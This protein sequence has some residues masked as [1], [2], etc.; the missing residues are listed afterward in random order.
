MITIPNNFNEQH[1]G[2]FKELIGM[3]NKLEKDLE[4]PNCEGNADKVR[5]LAEFERQ[6][7]ARGF[8]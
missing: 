7:R 3:F 4:Y 6:L 1:F 8:L 2:K 5:I